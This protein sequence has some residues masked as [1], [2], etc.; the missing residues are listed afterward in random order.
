MQM[1]NATLNFPSLSIFYD[2][3]SSKNVYKTIAIL[4]QGTEYDSASNNSRPRIAMRG[5][6]ATPVLSLEAYS[7]VV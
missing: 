2:T 5:D 1:R 6:F 3:I 4:N 7:K